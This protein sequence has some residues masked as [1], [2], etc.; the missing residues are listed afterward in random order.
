MGCNSSSPTTSAT[1]KASMQKEKVT[2]GYWNFRGLCRANPARYLLNYGKV[3]YEEKSYTVGEDEWPKTKDTLGFEF[4]NMP[5]IIVGDFKLTET[6]AVHQYIAEKFCPAVNGKTPKER[7]YRYRLQMVANDAFVK[8]ITTC[9]TQA[10]KSVSCA[11]FIDG[12]QA[13]AEHM[14]SAQFLGGDNPCIAD[15]ILFEHIEYALGFSE[16]K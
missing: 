7:A 13:L 6:F 11:A 5:Y 9:F 2:L 1:K 14:G 16:N 15:F 3:Q 8:A 12:L 4:P 10:E